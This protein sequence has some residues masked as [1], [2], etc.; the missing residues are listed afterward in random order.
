M[1]AS[2]RPTEQVAEE[3]VQQAATAHL[4]APEALLEMALPAADL[5]AVEVA[6][7]S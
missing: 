6:A 7:P 4:E 1:A 2:S 3:V 5:A